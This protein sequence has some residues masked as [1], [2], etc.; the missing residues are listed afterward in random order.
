MV[1]PV[2]W[3]LQHHQIPVIQNMPCW[4]HIG[5]IKTRRRLERVAPLR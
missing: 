4:L 3:R 2:E 1:F 5:P